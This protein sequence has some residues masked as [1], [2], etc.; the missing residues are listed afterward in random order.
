M[1]FIVEKSNP[2]M[3]ATSVIKKK[4]PKENNS[5]I[6]ENSLS[7]TLGQGCQ[8]FLGTAYQNGKYIPN[9]HKLHQLATKHTRWPYVK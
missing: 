9:Y 7:V 3:S 1:N 2:K 5:K 6:C 8:I 4:I